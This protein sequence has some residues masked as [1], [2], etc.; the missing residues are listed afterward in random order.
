MLRQGARYL[1]VYFT[2]ETGDEE[3]VA[4]WVPEPEAWARRI[5]EAAAAAGAEVKLPQ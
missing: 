3:G 2:A 4:F 5:S 1:A